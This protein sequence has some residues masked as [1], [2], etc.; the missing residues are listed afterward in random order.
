MKQKP[1]NEIRSSLQEILERNGYDYTVYVFGS[2]ETGLCLPWSDLDLILVSKNQSK[3]TIVSEDKLKEIQCLL[4]NANW[5][6]KP[7]LVTNYRVFPYITFSTDENHG[8][9]K[10]NLTI[11]DKNNY[12]YK[13]AK[14][15]KKFVETYENLKPIVLVLKHLFKYCFTFPKITVSA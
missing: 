2:F 9:M 1:I 4:G 13:C 5:I 12:G 11:Q 7:I 3:N 8:F 10:V 15:T 14:L 6:N